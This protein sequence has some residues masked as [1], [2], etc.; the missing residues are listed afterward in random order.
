MHIPLLG[1]GTTKYI[2]SGDD[3]FLCCQHHWYYTQYD[4][5]CIHRYTM[6]RT[7]RSFSRVRKRKPWQLYEFYLGFLVYHRYN[8]CTSISY[9]L[10]VQEDKG[11]ASLF[12][13][14]SLCLLSSKP[15]VYGLLLAITLLEQCVV[16]ILLVH[17]QLH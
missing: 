12:K 7:S 8:H 3:C 11:R 9:G 2:K 10:G 5:C 17:V 1:L 6:K 15:S 14:S 16:D 13:S 4:R